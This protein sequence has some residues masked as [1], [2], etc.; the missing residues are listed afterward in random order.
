LREEIPEWKS[1][2]H[3]LALAGVPDKI[4][5]ILKLLEW[6][7]LRTDQLREEFIG[8]R[9][10][11]QDQLSERKFFY[12]KPERVRFYDIPFEGWGDAPNRFPQVIPDIE[13]A[14]KCVALERGTAC[15]FHLMRVAELG[16][17]KLAELFSV[18]SVTKHTSVEFAQWGQILE[19]LTQ[20]VAALRG[21]PKAQRDPQLTEYTE[22]L[23][24]LQG[25]KDA[26]RN[27]VAHVRV[28]YSPEQAYEILADV[29][30]L[31]RRLAGVKP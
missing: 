6:P 30:R 16:L 4:A 11:I 24:S 3:E 5:H 7:L 20:K 22:L 23:L 8:L 18:T 10:S 27:Q 28:S 17:R 29:Q 2:A 12:I 14:G 1:L 26:W 25:F 21:A 15:V 19:A 13:E 9:H 31:M